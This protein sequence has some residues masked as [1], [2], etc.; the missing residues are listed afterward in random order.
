MSD[1]AGRHESA[2]PTGPPRAETGGG[3]LWFR[4]FAIALVP[5]LVLAAIGL[6]LARSPGVGGVELSTPVFQRYFLAAFLFA[7]LLGGLLSL[8]FHVA[9]GSR[10]AA[11]RRA[12][13][14][15][16]A[17][18]VR[19]LERES[20]WGPLAGLAREA[21]D[22]LQRT[23]SVR[24]EAEELAQ[25]RERLDLLT[26]GLEEWGATEWSGSLRVDPGLGTLAQALETL[27]ARLAERDHEAH[28]AA[29]LA[30]ETAR[31][32][33]SGVEL[34]SREATKSAV[35]ATAI[36]RDLVALRRALA[37]PGAGEAPEGAPA[38][39]AHFETEPSIWE[40]A[41]GH[42]QALRSRLEEEERRSLALALRLAAARLRAWGGELA[43]TPTATAA[44]EGSARGGG[45]PVEALA[46]ASGG[47][48][49][50][51]LACRGLGDE[52]RG[53]EQEFAAIARAGEGWAAEPRDAGVAE[54]A[55][56]A[57]PGAAVGENEREALRARLAEIER[58]G[59]RLAALS[60]R[61]ERHA[62]LAARLARSVEE[63]V[64]GLGT[65]FEIPPATAGDP[66]ARTETVED[67]A[68]ARRTVG[69]PLR[70][71]TRDDIVPEEDESDD[72]ADSGGRAVESEP[73]GDA[74][75]GAR[76][77]G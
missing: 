42:C 4:L 6:L 1:A 60:N 35:E 2:S 44:P 38:A 56:G 33:R 29:L 49:E 8:W 61:A 19:A 11:L 30:L 71:L 13:A 25:L 10:L 39:E 45:S 31:E 7:V 28:Q 50:V 24:T 64:S 34:A 57:R 22:L 9:L 70:L 14:G 68:R 58:R 37:S 67:S 74:P 21:L 23:H 15:G 16:R 51:A 73:R 59:E 46:T 63:D 75:E 76:G 62:L 36:V 43:E 66:P 26:A 3:G 18:E 5:L 53:L 20:G 17:T 40:T 77:D 32:A 65:R 48:R 55:G 52:V 47:L 69:G 41:V 12:L 54:P 27:H 72:E